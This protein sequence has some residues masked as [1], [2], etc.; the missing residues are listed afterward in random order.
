MQMG[1][2]SDRFR[3]E[4]V[5][6]DSASNTSFSDDWSAAMIDMYPGHT[7]KTAMRKPHAQTRTPISEVAAI[8]LRLFLCSVILYHVFLLYFLF[9]V[10][11]RT[12]EPRSKFNRT[13]PSTSSMDRKSL[14]REREQSKFCISSTDNFKPIHC[15]HV[16]RCCSKRGTTASRRVTEF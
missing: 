4:A 16:L 2:R 12:P 11:V 14:W 15:V 13:C 7:R 3:S 1:S 8:P 6:G 9:E 5:P 10:R